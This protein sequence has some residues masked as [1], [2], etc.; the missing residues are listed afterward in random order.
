MIVVLKLGQRDGD[1]RRVI[2][3]RRV[4][5]ETGNSLLIYDALQQ[6]VAGIDGGSIARC[7]RKAKGDV[8]DERR[9]D[10]LIARGKDAV[11][12]LDALCAVGSGRIGVVVLCARLE[13]HHLVRDGIE[14]PGM[15]DFVEDDMRILVGHVAPCWAVAN[16]ARGD[17]ADFAAARIDGYCV[18]RS[19][20]NGNIVSV[21]ARHRESSRRK[22]SPTS[23]HYIPPYVWHKLYHQL[24]IW[25]RYTFGYYMEYGRLP[26]QMQ[27]PNRKTDRVAGIWQRVGM[28]WH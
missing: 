15:F 24:A 12:Q 18:R 16:G 11:N 27:S 7:G 23:F 1:T 8:A 22:N 25:H 5:C 28:A 19:S 20:G 6:V 9:T 10:F 2:R 4:V 3:P 14:H 13:C 26:S 17:R 21:C